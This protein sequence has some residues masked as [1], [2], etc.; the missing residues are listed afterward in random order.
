MRIFSF[1]ENHETEE[2]EKKITQLIYMYTIITLN[3]ASLL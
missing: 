1:G 3:P 2:K